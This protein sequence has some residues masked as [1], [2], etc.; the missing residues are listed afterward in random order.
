MVPNSTPQLHG[1]YYWSHDGSAIV[2][3][4][5]KFSDAAR[6]STD[7]TNP[8]HQSP[9]AQIATSL[10]RPCCTII[11]HQSWDGSQRSVNCDREVILHVQQCC[12]Q[13]NR[14]REP[15]A[16]IA[17]RTNRHIPHPTVPYDKPWI[18][19]RLLTLSRLKL[20]IVMKF[21]VWIMMEGRHKGRIWINMEG[22]HQGRRLA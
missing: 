17:A 4:Y 8:T 16:P 19:I 6:N 3:S 5:R 14:Y 22:R 10:K 13:F 9:H 7:I 12:S 11:L 1:K 18:Q 2:K 21:L 20:A 15:H